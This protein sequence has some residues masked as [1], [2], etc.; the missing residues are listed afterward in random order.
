M[1]ISNIE[2]N[3]SHNLNLFYHARKEDTVMKNFSVGKWFCNGQGRMS[4]QGI[5]HGDNL[6][7]ALKVAGEAF[8]DA[9]IEEQ[10]PEDAEFMIMKSHREHVDIDFSGKIPCRI[11]ILKDI[12][13]RREANG[14]LP[15]ILYSLGDETIE[16]SQRCRHD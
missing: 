15:K 13:P 5:W 8:L 2:N 10:Y 12:D 16:I 14:E 4:Y 9:L 11:T 7:E 1:N 6:R 3:F